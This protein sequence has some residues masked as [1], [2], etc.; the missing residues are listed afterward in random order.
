MTT[1]QE[2]YELIVRCAR[3]VILDLEAHAFTPQDS[4]AALG[5]NSMD[6]A[7]IV[8]MVMEALT[9]NIPRA[10]LFGPTNIGELA[11]LLHEKLR[12]A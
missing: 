10:E 12:A 9:L 1:K 4:L 8:M 6:R 5:A 11:D 3:E 2:I 7:E